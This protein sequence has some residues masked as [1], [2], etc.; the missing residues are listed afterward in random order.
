MAGRR[1]SFVI[2][3]LR[4]FYVKRLDIMRFICENIRVI[5]IMIIIIIKR[6]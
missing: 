3:V 1:L 6:K 5:L 2:P 4:E